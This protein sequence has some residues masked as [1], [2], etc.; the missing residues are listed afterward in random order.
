MSIK[1]T[2]QNERLIM[3]RRPEVWRAFSQISQWPQWNP[4]VKQ[5]LEI[6]PLLAGSSFELSLAPLGLHFSAPARLEEVVVNQR[7]SYSGA[8]LGIRTRHSFSFWD[9]G[10]CTQVVSLEEIWGWPLVFLRPFVSLQRLNQASQL[11][12][13]SLAERAEGA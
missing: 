6:K 5:M 13:K 11:W 10:A 3:A 9:K 1:L 2:L 8:W 7:L 12:L 4:W